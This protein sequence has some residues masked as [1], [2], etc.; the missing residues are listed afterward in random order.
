MPEMFKEM[1]MLCNTDKGKQVR[2]HYIKM[3]DTLHLY[4]EYQS[5]IELKSLTDKLDKLLITTELERQKADERD[6]IQNEKITQLLGFATE[7]S[8]TLKVV[9]KNQVE[10]SIL[11]PDKRHTFIILKDNDVDSITPY[12]AIRSQN[13]SSDKIIN[14]IRTRRNRS[15][16]VFVE[17]DQPN[18]VAFFNIIKSELC[19]NIER[20]GQWFTIVGMSEDEFKTKITD[21]NRRHRRP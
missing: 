19:D 3:V 21:I 16:S 12:Y 5:K 7:T 14:N 17:L 20:V 6:R 8:E 9:A 2:K 10:V 18:S 11:K 1:L 13:G 15:M 4:I